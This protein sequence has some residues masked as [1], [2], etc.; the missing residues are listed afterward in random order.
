MRIPFPVKVLG[1]G[2]LANLLLIPLLA[3]LGLVEGRNRRQMETEAQVARLT[4]AP[5]TLFGPLLVVPYTVEVKR[6]ER[7][8][9]TGT[10]QDVWEEV[11]RERCLTPR[12]LDR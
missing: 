1:V 7:N 9:R 3:T 10:W 11:Q 5:Q 6:T 2:G 8:E 12:E 4:A